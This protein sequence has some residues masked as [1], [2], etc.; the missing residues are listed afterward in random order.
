MWDN[1]NKLLCAVGI[2]DHLYNIICASMSIFVIVQTYLAITALSST[3]S[4]AR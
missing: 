4:L 2:N 3:N 1:L